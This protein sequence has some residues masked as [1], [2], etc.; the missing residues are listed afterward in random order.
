MRTVFLFIVALALAIPASAKAATLTFD[1]GTLTYTAE[2]GRANSVTIVAVGGL[3]GVRVGDDD[4]FAQPPGCTPLDG[5]PNTGYACPGVARVVVNAGDLDDSVTAADDVPVPL[6]IDGEA[7]NDDLGGGAGDD[8][9]AGGDGQDQLAGGSGNDV[10]DG[11]A[12]DDTLDGED[13]SDRLLGGPGID[14]A[15]YVAPS[16]T[17]LYTVT[18]DGMTNDG[19]PGENDEVAADVENVTVAGLR[20]GVPPLDVIVVP[21][22]STLIGDAG[23]NELTADDGDDTLVG[24]AGNDILTGLGGDDTIDARDG[25]MDRV[26]CGPG[27]DAVTAD[28]LDL[29]DSDCES[30]SVANVAAAA[31]APPTIAWTAPKAGARIRGNPAT[32]LTVD[33][34]DDHGVARV[35]FL[36]GNRVL[37][38]DTTAPYTCAYR[39]RES[40]LGRN[41]L[42]AVA[43]DGAGQS[44]SAQRSVTVGR[45]RPTLTLKVLRS[46]TRYTARGT[47][48]RPAALTGRCSGTVTLIAVKDKRRIAT[49]KARLT[50][51]CTYRIVLYLGVADPGFAISYPGSKLLTSVRTP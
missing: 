1:G 10:L 8:V 2:G 11:G 16:A 37:C 36:D 17:P 4:L 24:G 23:P 31:D 29:V 13:G 20:A 43:I 3:V 32:R 18:L 27:T 42:T 45:F 19:R 35:R 48:K 38:E 22:A 28:T 6:T 7:G 47:L 50:R 21:Q 49:R 41:T 40:D 25:F 46:G 51:N 9:L 15:R 26:H 12:G 33:A 44:A 39:P 34:S 5:P 30:V 14:R